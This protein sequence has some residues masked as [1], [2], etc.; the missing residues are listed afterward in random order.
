M[1]FA[2]ALHLRFRAD[3]AATGAA[4]NLF[5]GLSKASARDG[6]NTAAANS[7]S[8]SEI[9]MHQVSYER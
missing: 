2:S 4:P 9:R 5:N 3:H 7:K 1:H 6:E 8:V